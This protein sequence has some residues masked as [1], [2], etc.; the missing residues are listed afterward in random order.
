[1]KKNLLFLFAIIL[2][3]AC[4]SS[5][6]KKHRNHEAIIESSETSRINDGKIWA[7]LYQ[8]RAAEYK[9]LCFQA[10]NIAKL[11]LDMAIAK[12]SDKPF[13]VV[14]DIDETLLDNSHY[15]AARAVQNLDYDEATWK[16]WTG[17]AVADSVPGAPSFLKYA[18]SKG[19][20]VFY[21]TNRGQDERSGTLKNLKHFD[22][23]FADSLHVLFK[24][25]ISSKEARRQQVLNTHNVVLLCGDNLPDFDA[26]YDNQ[27]SEASRAATTVKLSKEF[28]SRYII[29][30]NLS[31]GDFEGALFNFKYDLTPV[32]KDSVIID[33]IRTGDSR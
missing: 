2:I 29:I 1:M 10:Y 32:Q 25:K 11:R 16:E 13:A 31:Y 17:K 24:D 20:T 14:T 18:A 23:P 21:I 27:P 30:P 5:C 7:S 33:K 26:L 4:W 28:G 6:R 12:H 8:Q 15:D 22:L 3:S 9:A 19:V